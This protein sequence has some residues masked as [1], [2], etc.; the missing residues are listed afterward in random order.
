MHDAVDSHLNNAAESLN[1]K[2]RRNPL[3]KYFPT[4]LFSFHQSLCIGQLHAVKE[5]IITNAISYVV[6]LIRAI[7]YFDQA[8]YK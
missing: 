5:G 6:N 7:S 3:L 8:H 1:L 4:N 2:A